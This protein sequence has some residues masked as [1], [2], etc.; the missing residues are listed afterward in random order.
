MWVPVNKFRTQH[1]VC[2]GGIVSKVI[3]EP[4]GDYIEKANI[5]RFM[6]KNGIKTYDE[7][8]K[9]STDDIKWFWDAALEDLGVDWY[10]PYTQTLDMSEGFPWTKWFIGGKINIVHNC[11]DRHLETRGDQTVIIAERD[12][13]PSRKVTYSELNRQVCKLANGLKSLGIKKGDFIGIYM[14]MAPEIVAAFFACLKIGAIA[15]PV[16]SGFGPTALATRL[17]DARVLFTADGTTRRGKKVAIKNE[18]DKALEMAPSIE[19]VIVLRYAGIEVPWNDKRD[20]WWDDFIKDQPG[21]CETEV[22]EAED[23]AITIYSSGTTGKPKGTIHTHAGALAQCAKELGYNFDV[24]PDSIFFWFTD[25]G[26]MMGP[27]EMIGVQFHGGTYVIFDGAPNYPNPDRLWEVIETHKV[28]TLGISPTAIRMFIT[29][30]EEWVKK[31]DL[32]SL[33]YLGSTGEPW[34]PESYMW[35]FNVVGDGR[36]PIINISGGTEIIGCLLAPLPIHPLKPCSLQGPALAMD[37]DCFDE[38]GKPVRGA[39]GHLVCKK[40]G[41]SMT[42][43]FLG[44]PERYIE[45]YFSRWPDVWYHGDWAE[46]DEDGYWYL[47]GRSDDTIKVAGKRTGP[48]EIEAALIEHSV[49]VEA[50]AIGVPHDIKGQ[51]V[52]SFVVL[53]PGEEP[54][55]ELR[56][57]LSDLVVKHLGKTLRPEKVLFVGA[58]PK[59]RSAKIVRGVIRKKYLGQDVADVSSVENPESLDEIANAK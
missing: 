38:E 43:G 29:Y 2:G 20:I 45:T 40:P 46:V 51:T 44:D 37:I 25:I 23:R 39:V 56:Q 57:E 27:W 13:G 50:A 47:L 55:E 26:W 32:S 11:I 59:T 6:K 33:K 42:K 30:G 24:K 5:T 18:A 12:E 15:I 17:E 3:W 28:D 1:S 58:L 41:P 53:K 4:Y 48:A 54:S 21:E 34:D 9:R 14:P 31:H 49:V 52:V 19:K 10:K 36:C 16:F 22:L 8:I 35:F 7:L